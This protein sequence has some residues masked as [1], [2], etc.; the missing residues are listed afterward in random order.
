MTFVPIHFQCATRIEHIQFDGT[1]STLNKQIMLRPVEG[2]TPLQN[3]I[4]S[5]MK[6]SGNE[7]HIV[8][9]TESL[10]LMRY[11]SGFHG[12]FFRHASHDKLNTIQFVNV[13]VEVS[14]RFFP[15]FFPGNGFLH[16]L[17]TVSGRMTVENLSDFSCINQFFCVM[18]TIKEIHDVSRHE[19]YMIFFTGFYHLITVRVGEGDRL[20]T[21]NILSVLRCQ[22][23]RLFM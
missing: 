6:T 5:I 10:A 18:H 8:L 19:N 7:N 9:I 2:G 11:I 23:H 20:F 22:N 14:S 16:V 17:P 3:G 15:D 21:K 12:N 1:F 13:V 4:T